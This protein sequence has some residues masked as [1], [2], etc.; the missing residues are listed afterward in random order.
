[1]ASR[2]RIS[3][4]LV[5]HV[6]RIGDDDAVLA[7]PFGVDVVVADTEARHDLELREARHDRSVDRAVT[8]DRRDR[9]HLGADRIDEGVRVGSREGPVQGMASLLQR[10]LDDRFRSEHHHVGF[11]A[12]HEQSPSI[13]LIV[14]APARVPRGGEAQSPRAVAPRQARKYRM[15]AGGSA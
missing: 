3:D 6:R 1:V 5:E 9:T 12:G 14:N 7:S 11:V 15:R 10:I 2:S 8:R 13:D 4:L